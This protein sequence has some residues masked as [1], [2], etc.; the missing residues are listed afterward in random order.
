MPE[1]FHFLAE[2][3]HA[4]PLKRWLRRADKNLFEVAL[5]TR[6]LEDKP[7]KHNFRKFFE[8]INDN[9]TYLVYLILLSFIWIINFFTYFGMSIYSVRL[10]HT[11]YLFSGLVELPAYL[12]APLLL[13]R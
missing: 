2:H 5:L 12:M 6:V 1:S 7:V 11:N 10:E 3:S 9:R 13:D 4:K 8:F